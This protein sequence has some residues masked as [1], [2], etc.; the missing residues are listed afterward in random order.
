M[1]SLKSRLFIF[2]L[3]YQNILRF[4]WKRKPFVDWN[5]SIPALRQKTEKAG[6]LL[7]KMPTGIR[8]SPAAINGLAAEWV[9]PAESKSKKAI[10]YFHGGGYVIGSA[11]GHRPHVAKFVNGSS[12]AALVFDYRLAPEHPFPAALDD[13]ITAYQFLL[14]QGLAHSDIIFMGDSAG[15]G[16]CLATLLKLKDQGIPLPA[17]AV[18][19]SP[20]TDLKGTGESLRTN[21]KVDLLTWRESWT[22][23]AKYYAAEND[24][25]LPWISP[26]YGNLHGLPPLLIYVGGDELL[27]D[28]STRF[29]EKALAAG[30]DV[31]LKIGPG[32]F[33]CYPVCS[34]LFPEAKLAME[35]ICEFLKDVGHS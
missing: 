34:P 20:W 5:T 3:R 21:E 33:H 11:Q 14:A 28:D 17:A 8:I 24:P 26:L 13:A 19:L 22:V 35:E 10:L 12:V 1:S 4:Q 27:R 18:A 7:G 16:L 23:F 31:T 9:R 2:V 30:V 15:G 32:M 25:S 29:A 6:R